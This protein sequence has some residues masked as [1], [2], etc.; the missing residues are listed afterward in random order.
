MIETYSQQI[1]EKMNKYL[2]SKKKLKDIPVIIAVYSQNV[3][4]E[5]IYNGKFIYS[6]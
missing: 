6:I 3:D 4:S 2:Q 1:I 5:N